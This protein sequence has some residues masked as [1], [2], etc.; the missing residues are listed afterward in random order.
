MFIHRNNL[1]ILNRNHSTYSHK[2]NINN[3]R[4]VTSTARS[5]LA[6]SLLHH[7]QRPSPHRSAR[8][9]VSFIQ[10]NY[11]Q[12]FTSL[13]IFH[14]LLQHWKNGIEWKYLRMGTECLMWKLSNPVCHPTSDRLNS[15]TSMLAHPMAWRVE[16][17]RASP[18]RATI[19][20][21]CQLLFLRVPPGRR[22][23][24]QKQN[25]I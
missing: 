3:I 9:E 13:Y 7:Q 24:M 12:L 23:K 15:F 14:L 6:A 20:K 4:N 17:L 5:P 21:G 25:L 19:Q 1:L 18:S 11:L 16:V 2:F 8:S 10:W 22:D